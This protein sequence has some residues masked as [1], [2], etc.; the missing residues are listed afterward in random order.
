VG[1][2]VKAQVGVRHVD[3]RAGQIDFGQDDRELDPSILRASRVP[4]SAVSPGG[5]TD[6]TDG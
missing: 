4:V 3:G 2:E 5:G 1:Q 6:A